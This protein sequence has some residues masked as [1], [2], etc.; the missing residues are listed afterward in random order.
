M[1]VRNEGSSLDAS[2]GAILSQDYPSDRLEIL[3]AD[4]CSTDGTRQLIET[5]KQNHPSL[6]LFENSARIVSTGL[7]LALRRARGEVILRVDGHTNIAPDYV[8]QCVAALSRSGADNV[9][10]RI[11]ATNP[12][13][14]GA[15]AAIATSSPF[16][17]GGA[18]FHYSD[19]EEFVDTVYLGAWPR[20]VFSQIGL[21]DE[22]LV[23][24]QDDEF[25]Y[26][27]REHGGRIL[28]SPKIQSIYASRSGVNIP[29]MDTGK[30]VYC[31]NILARCNLASLCLLLLCSPC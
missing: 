22:E 28:L 12:G 17:V 3:V 1:P 5:L 30:C 23:R 10:G 31:R 24:N 6:K 25:N 2:L 19:R 16:G 21:F 29:S 11:N 26:R 8:S 18:R 4:G 14:F 15:A 9:G 7:N 27:L 13:L 20:R